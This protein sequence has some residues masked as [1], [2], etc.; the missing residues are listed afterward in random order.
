MTK[1]AA[2]ER[3]LVVGL[4]GAR[5]RQVAQDSYGEDLTDVAVVEWSATTVNMRGVC[6]THSCV[7]RHK[8]MHILFLVVTRVDDFQRRHAEYGMS[9]HAFS[10]GL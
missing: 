3:T 9:H 5:H 7:I 10:R 1:Q 6:F 8:G 2:P 4:W